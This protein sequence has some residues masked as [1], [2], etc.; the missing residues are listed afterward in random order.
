MSR[1]RELKSFQT[2]TGNRLL[3][4]IGVLGVWGLLGCQPSGPVPY[5][6][7]YGGLSGKV[8]LDGNPVAER[9][10]VLITNSD[11]H[12]A[13]AMVDSQG[14]YL[15]KKAPVGTYQVA[16]SMPGMAL[17]GSLAPADPLK[18][19][20]GAIPAKYLNPSTSGVTVTIEADEETFVDI[21]LKS[22]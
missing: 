5:S 14:D 9:T 11:G 3:A 17:D 19:S 10:S 22:K 4:I 6:G 13:S 7:P 8:T 18:Q 20:A 16:F 2:A 21:S 12:A 1:I 15:I